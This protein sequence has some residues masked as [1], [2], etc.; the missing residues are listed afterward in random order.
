MN[1]IRQKVEQKSKVE[2]IK[3]LLNIIGHAGLTKDQT[4]NAISD[5]GALI[6]KEQFKQEE[7]L[8]LR[9]WIKE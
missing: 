8:E 5:V 7:L 1:D 9:N 3:D 4:T 6:V 2:R